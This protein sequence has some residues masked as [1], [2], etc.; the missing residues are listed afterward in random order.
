MKNKLTNFFT[1]LKKQDEYDISFDKLKELIR[2]YFQH[3]AK[4]YIYEDTLVDCL[5]VHPNAKLI[6][7]N[8][9]Q[10]KELVNRNLNK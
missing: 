6:C 5:G 9:P 4:Y 7:E 10:W 3:L 1:Y 2:P 8:L